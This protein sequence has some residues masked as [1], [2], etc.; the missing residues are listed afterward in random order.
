MQAI[1]KAVVK[2][3]IGSAVETRN[4][5]YAGCDEM[6][7]QYL[8]GDVDGFETYLDDIYSNMVVITHNLVTF[9][10][11]EFSTWDGE[12]FQYHSRVP[13][14]LQGTEVV[15]LSSYQA[16]ILFTFNTAV[17]KMRGR[18]FFPGVDE[19]MTELGALTLDALA[20]CAQVVTMAITG[21]EGAVGREW[22]PGIPG[23][24]SPFAPWLT[25]SVGTIL[26]TMRRRKP[27]Y[28]I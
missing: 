7:L 2:G 11:Y 19:L 3:R 10:E 15:D 25:G 18:K 12:E 23:V 22:F 1:M 5:W 13:K 8:A 21:F 17:K 26:S 24:G 14:A 6:S 20:T 27:G 9:Y 16:A 4:I 28:G